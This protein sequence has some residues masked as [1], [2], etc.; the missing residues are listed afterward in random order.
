MLRLMLEQIKQRIDCESQAEE[1]LIN[2]LTDEI[3]QLSQ[4]IKDKTN[5]LQEAILALQQVVKQDLIT[6]KA[7]KSIWFQLNSDVQKW[8]DEPLMDVSPVEIEETH[9]FL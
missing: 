2:E 1:I 4:V 6:L 8:L 3:V 7:R 5:H 9:V